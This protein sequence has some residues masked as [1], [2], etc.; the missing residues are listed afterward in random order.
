MRRQSL[1]VVAPRRAE[2]IEDDLLPPGP[3]EVLVATRAGAISIGTE[4]PHWV[5]TSRNVVPDAYPLMTGYESLGVVLAQGE[6]V[7]DLRV[8]AR[9]LAF[10]G[11][12]TAALLPAARA[13]LVP[14]GVS[15]EA[16]LLAIL[17]CDAGKGVRAVRPEVTDSA[18]VT[19]GGAMGLLTVFMLSASGRRRVDVIEPQAERRVLAL[20]LGARRA[21]A[22]GDEEGLGESYDV[23]LECSGYDVAFAELQRRMRHGGRICVLSD[24][25]REPLTLT[26]HFHASELRIAASS[27]GWD[28]HRHAAWY[29]DILPAYEKALRELFDAEIPADRLPMQFADLVAGASTPIKVLVRYLEPAGG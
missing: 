20:R 17:S 5:G 4:V 10:Y 6:G 15:D 2:W 26:S 14:D 28:Y 25:N 3:E 29:F 16:A 7:R 11:H 24:G 13:I 9:V 18:L 12:R 21:V 22:P 27:D 1:Y 8:G 19:G 23:G